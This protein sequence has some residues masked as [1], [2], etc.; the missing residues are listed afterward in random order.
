MEIRL[1]KEQKIVLLQALQRGIL[2]PA[3]VCRWVGE[4]AG[5]MSDADLIYEVDVLK[6]TLPKDTR[7]RIR[8][9]AVCVNCD[10]YLLE[11][12][13]LDLSLLTNDELITL[14]KLLIKASPWKVGDYRPDPGRP[15]R[16]VARVDE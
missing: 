14:H 5:N 11:K 9:M 3:E 13:N 1:T 16:G 7:K 2:D 4:N 15:P 10:K 8:E 6:K 12:A